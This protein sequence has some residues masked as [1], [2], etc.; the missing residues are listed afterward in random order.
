MPDS[1]SRLTSRFTSAIRRVHGNVAPTRTRTACSANTFPMA[2]TFR[3][4]HDV[5]LILSLVHSI[6]DHVRHCSFARPLLNSLKLLQ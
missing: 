3:A 1:K 2:Q 5:N 4:S 6:L